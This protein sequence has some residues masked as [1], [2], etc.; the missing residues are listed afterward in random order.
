MLR[1][2]SGSPFFRAFAGRKHFPPRGCP[3]ANGVLRNGSGQGR[4]RKIFGGTT[5]DAAQTRSAATEPWGSQPEAMDGRE[6]IPRS[7]G[8]QKGTKLDAKCSQP[9]AGVPKDTIFGMPL[10]DPAAPVFLALPV[11]GNV[12]QVR[13]PHCRVRRFLG[14]H[15]PCG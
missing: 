9:L 7:S 6:T 15:K 2:S 10:T 3:V 4:V 13:R 5:A 14:F 12:L 8:N 1:R 11:G